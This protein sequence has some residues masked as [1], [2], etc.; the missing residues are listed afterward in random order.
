MQ[1]RNLG[2]TGIKV[3]P[4]CLGAMMFG[5]IANS[6]HDDCVR[7]IHKALDAGI[8]ILDTADRYSQGESE[9]IVGKALKG[10]RDKVVLAT[11][12]HGPMGQEQNQQGSSRRWI[13][14][15][16]E[17]SL[18]RLQTDH[19]DLYQIHRPS[20]DTDV[21]E[22]LSVLTDLMR[23]GK[24]RAIGSSTFPA[25]EIVEAQWVAERRGLARFRTEQP[26][27]SILNRSI[28]GEVL[29]LC[30]TYGM[31]ALVWSPLAKGLLTG[32]YRK[33]EAMPDSLRVKVFAKQMS[34]ERNLDAV[35]RLI[36]VAQAAGLSLTHL[37]MAFVMA[38]PGV[39]SA[40]LGPRTMP[41]L[42]DL[43]AGA[44][45]RLDD[46]TLDRID[47]IVAPGTNVAPVGGAYEP[48]AVL[49]ATL[50]RRPLIERR[51]A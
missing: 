23:A 24:V 45:V 49:D 50:R 2:R 43:L 8:N 46:E 9:E 18:R 3:S 15:A 20:P 19:I 48:P 1:Y 40:I 10:R 47:T 4:Y 41:Q 25:S 26:P 33:G 30:Q 34:D 42:D 28:E 12:V 31:G 44:E 21:E 13:T 51:A 38:H 22:T 27:Y 37:A 16:V 32:R 17:G 5:G 7:I 36:P 29:P 11:K 39:T 35:E 6:D 14:Q